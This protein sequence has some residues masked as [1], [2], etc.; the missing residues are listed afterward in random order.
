MVVLSTKFKSIVTASQAS[1]YG[2]IARMESKQP[3]EITP[4]ENEDETQRI[5]TE[6]QAIPSPSTEDT[7]ALPVSTSASFTDISPEDASRS[8]KN[9]KAWRWVVLIGIL[10]LLAIAAASAVGGYLS[11]IDQRTRYEATQVAQKVAE[12][13]Q[14]GLQDMQAGQ[15]ELARQRFEYVIRL[16]PDYPGVTENL[17]KV[18]LELNTTATPTPVPTPTLTPTPDLRSADEL[19]SQ[20]QILLADQKW[21]EAI[22]T[23]LKLRKD[24]PDFHTVEVDSMFYVALRNRGVQR[25]L[26]EGDLEGGTYDLALAE[27]FGPLDIE[28]SNMRT[29]ADL[30]VTGASFW[31]LDWGQAAYYFGQIV[32]VAP[33][34][35]D[36][37]NMTATER[38]RIASIK[39]GD[40]LAENKEWCKAQEQY[41]AAYNLS[42]DPTLE[43]TATWAGDK[44]R[45]GEKPP[46]EDRTP[47]PTPEVTP[48][49]E[50]PATTEPPPEETPPTEPPYPYPTP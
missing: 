12:Q 18:L 22:D 30:Y 37:T 44:C 50:I 14:L 21:S 46:R 40:F 16:A 41:Q 19:F 25:I 1:F 34:L 9:S 32:M 35:R 24:K 42:P 7:L 47:E 8:K 39:Y 17:A 15:Y 48:T 6:D 23:L 10:A 3:D 49:P 27:R 2:I 43:A 13:F 36:H 45:E 26:T 33:N 29:W 5:Q 4:L 20:S 11:G 31:G 28:A 38:F